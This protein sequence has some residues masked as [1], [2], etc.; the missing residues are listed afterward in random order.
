MQVPGFFVQEER[1][2]DAN[3]SNG[4][5]NRNTHEAQAFKN[6]CEEIDK[7]FGFVDAIFGDKAQEVQLPF[8]CED[9]IVDWEFQAYPNEL[10]DLTDQFGGFQ[11]FGCISIKLRR[12]KKAKRRSHY[13]RVS[14]YWS[15]YGWQR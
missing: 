8:V 2:L 12:L 11:F 13:W 10:G 3:A 5:F 15:R 4:A 6:Q 9:R 1:V 7:Y 14:Y